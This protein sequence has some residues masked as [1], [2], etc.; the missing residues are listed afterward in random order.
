MLFTSKF[1]VGSRIKIVLKTD[2]IT[3]RLQLNTCITE[4]A[5]HREKKGHPDENKH[6]DWLHRR[7]FA[8]KLQ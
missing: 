3:T 5:S 2:G 4:S 1:R 8:L 6:P 7:N